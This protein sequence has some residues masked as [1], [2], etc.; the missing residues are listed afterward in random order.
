MNGPV[1]PGAGMPILPKFAAT[2]PKP[3]AILLHPAVTKIR[4]MTMRTAATPQAGSNE[5]A[6]AMRA[7][8]ISARDA[9]MRA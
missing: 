9:T 4:P 1:M 5:C 3:F 8:R 7:L 6:I 2:A